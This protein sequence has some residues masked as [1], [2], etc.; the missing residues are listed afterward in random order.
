MAE[1]D[2]S[3]LMQLLQQQIQGLKSA[4]APSFGSGVAEQ[5]S[6]LQNI[7]G[8]QFGDTAGFFTKAGEAAKAS[9]AQT[10]KQNLAQ[11]LEQAAAS[12]KT[13]SSAQTAAQTR[14]PQEGSVNLAN[15]LGQL[16]IKEQ[17]VL[18][19][20]AA[21]TS[22][23]ESDRAAKLQDLLGLQS[24]QTAQTEA[25][26]QE[27]EDQITTLLQLMK[28]LGG[29]GGAGGGGGSLGSLLGGGGGGGALGGG[30]G[31]AAG[32]NPFLGSLLQALKG[33]SG[34]VGLFGP[35]S[36]AQ[37]H[38]GSGSPTAQ[39]EAFQKKQNLIQQLLQAFG[40]AQ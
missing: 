34:G 19:Q 1:F 31:G 4:K 8:P 27:N 39:P 11:Q 13:F 24:Q 37:K 3:G 14:I 26:S 32:D 33:G 40:S 5:I 6:A 20:E 23:F 9:Q 15:I 30:G 28:G 12:G 16:G 7:Q 17:Q 21:A 2:I 10:T 35:G 18:G 22:A 29:G 38:M 36:M 25:F